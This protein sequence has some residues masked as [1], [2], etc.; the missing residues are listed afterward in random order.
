[1]NLILHHTFL[2]QVPK[3]GPG[4]VLNK[5]RQISIKIQMRQ[6]E[7]ER[8]LGLKYQEW[9]VLTE[10]NTFRV[11]QK[12]RKNWPQ[13]DVWQFLFSAVLVRTFSMCL[14]SSAAGWVVCLANKCH[15]T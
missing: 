15:K 14:R 5:A 4:M 7:V 1:M 13:R 6:G 8:H 12:I 9:M 2:T 3:L 10:V 11:R